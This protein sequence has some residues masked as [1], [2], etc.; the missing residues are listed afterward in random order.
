MPGDGSAGLGTRSMPGSPQPTPAADGAAVH[1]TRAVARSGQRHP[2]VPWNPYRLGRSC[3][4][5]SDCA[6]RIRPHTAAPARSGISSSSRAMAPRV[7]TTSRDASKRGSRTSIR[8]A[9]RTCRTAACTDL[10]ALAGVAPALPGHVQDQRVGHVALQVGPASAGHGG[11]V[12]RRQG[13]PADAQDRSAPKRRGQPLARKLAA[14]P[15]IR[16]IGRDCPWHRPPGARPRH[17]GP[18]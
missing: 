4:G 17:R 8:T 13:H 7:T 6:A 11:S 10:P 5:S 9:A 14:R 2:L 15:V 16:P 18:W 12:R 1:W 3:R